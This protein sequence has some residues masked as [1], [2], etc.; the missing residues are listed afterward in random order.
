MASLGLEPRAA[1]PLNQSE[2]SSDTC[3]EMVPGLEIESRLES[4]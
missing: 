3:S 2:I 1:E 4:R